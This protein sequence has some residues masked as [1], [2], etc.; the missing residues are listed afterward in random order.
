MTFQEKVKKHLSCYKKKNYPNLKNGIWHPKSDNVELKYAFD[1]WND[2]YKFNILK[3]YRDQFFASKYSEG[4]K[5]IK[6]HIYFHH[7]NS[8]QAMCIN[9]FYP[10]IV[11][12]Q[13]ELVLNFLGFPNEVIGYSSV[14]FE[15]VSKIDGKYGNRPT[16]FDFY[17]KTKSGKKFFF[18]IKYTEYDFGKAKNDESHINKY[19][20]IYKKNL[21]VVKSEYA[22]RLTFFKHYQLIRNLIHIDEGKYVVFLYPNENKKVKDSAIKAKQQILLPRYKT[23]LF[24]V[25]WEDIL[26]HVTSNLNHFKLRKHMAEFKKKY[27]KNK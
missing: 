24:N 16:N 14:E 12:R 10:L 5:A 25:G 17:F 1:N 23:N 21:N 6:R 20:Q 9:F 27:M 13:L 22:E 7:M 2:D 11:E 18:E 8:S 15:K 4:I 3:S 19:H 26:A